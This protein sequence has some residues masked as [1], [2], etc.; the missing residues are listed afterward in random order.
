M[1]KM[2]Y[3][4]TVLSLC[5]ALCAGC[6]GS[7][8][9]NK[10]TTPVPEASPTPEATA[11]PTPTNT[12]T[13]TKKPTPTPMGANLPEGINLLNTYGETFGRIGT[14]INSFQFT[15]QTA[16]ELLKKN[17]NSIT[18]ENEMKPQEILKNPNAMLT[19]DEAKE[20]GYVIPENY[21]ETV[22]PQLNFYYTD[23]ALEFCEKH[24]LGLRG[25]TLVWHSQTPTWFFREGYKTNGEYVTPEVMDARMEFYIRSVMGHVCDS[26]FGH[27]LYS[28]DVVNEYVHAENSDW[29]DV[30]GNEG[31]EPGFVKKA[32][33]IA[34]DVLK[35]Y[36]VRDK[37]SL[38]YNDFNTYSDAVHIFKLIRFVNED[39]KYCDGIGMQS[40]LK[41]QSPPP[42]KYK[43]A[44]EDFLEEGY[45]VQITEMD[46]E[47]S[48][49]ILQANYLY[50]IM[51]DLLELKMNGA[52]ITGITFWGLS[53]VNSWRKQNKPLLY[54][55]LKTPKQSYYRVLEAY[56]N[57][58]LYKND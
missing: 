6:G 24:N 28:W 52:N 49:P 3:T 40:H 31:L 15:D 19:I 43:M 41:T 25:H 29:E 32:F 8:D 34:D 26:E 54:S 13:P 4:F 47:N 11:T 33:Q 1:R 39:G 57:A 51:E 7:T 58:G 22:V 53:D 17:Y 18:L 30:Y 55:T 44:I 5:V 12:P 45:E 56:V 37:V 46:V 16:L 48:S 50:D 27:V 14:C 20:L 35:Q 9:K 21:K 23:R 42:I 10:Q 36:G 38:L 2:R